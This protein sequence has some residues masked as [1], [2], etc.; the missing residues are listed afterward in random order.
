LSFVVVG[1]TLMTVLNCR[2]NPKR[3]ERSVETEAMRQQQR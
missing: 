3:K 1:Y 2:Q